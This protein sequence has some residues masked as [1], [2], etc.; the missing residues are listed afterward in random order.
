MNKLATGLLAAAAVTMTV[1]WVNAQQDGDKPREGAQEREREQ[2]REAARQ[3]DGEGRGDRDPRGRGREGDRGRGGERGR[4]NAGPPRG[5]DGRRPA[6]GGT[7]VAALDRNGNGTLDSD[8][9]DQ[10]IVVLRRMDRNKD[11]RLTPDELGMLGR[12][13]GDRTPGDGDR[14]PRDGDRP[15]RDGDRPPRDGDRPSGERSDR[16][17]FSPEQMM[18]RFNESDTNKDGK[19]SKEEAPDRM[20]EGFDRLD[21]NKDGFVDKEEFGRMLQRFR[22]GQGRDGRPGGDRAENGRPGGDRPTRE[23]DRPPRDEDGGKRRR[24]DTE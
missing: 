1:D 9:I 3:R 20:K 23:G 10:A 6:V 18:A 16:G 21:G 19:L 12:P 14:P 5:G 7:I 17:G 11:G 13:G 4:P 2:P 22:R 15:P 24:P 8:E